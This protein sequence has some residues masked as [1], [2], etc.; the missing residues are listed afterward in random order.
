MPS[1][2]FHVKYINKQFTYSDFPGWPEDV[3]H[4][5]KG[6][7]AMVES[8]VARHNIQDNFKLLVRIADAPW[9]KPEGGP[10][11]DRSLSQLFIEPA[12]VFVFT[13]KCII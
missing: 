2:D 10:A 9:E 1:P 4:R 12:I 13:M 3:P 11:P 5:G 7:M 8:V 6:I